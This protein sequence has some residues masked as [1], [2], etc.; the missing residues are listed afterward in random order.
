MRLPH[1]QNPEKRA[2]AGSLGQNYEEQFWGNEKS[3]TK[4]EDQAFF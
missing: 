3:G 2:G 1:A 4:M